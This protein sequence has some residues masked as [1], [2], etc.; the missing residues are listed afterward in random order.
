MR[1]YHI[2]R[3]QMTPIF[4]GQP[5]QNKAFSNQNKGH[6]DSRYVYLDLDLFGGFLHPNIKRLSNWIISP[7]IGLDPGRH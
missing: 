1:V 5:P 7:E 4:E 2:P 3:T 6:L